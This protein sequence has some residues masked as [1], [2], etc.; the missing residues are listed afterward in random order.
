MREMN[1]IFPLYLPSPRFIIEV[2]EVNQSCIAMAKNRKFTPRTKHITIKYHHVRKHVITQANPD[3][4]I[5]LEYCSTHNQIAD[6]FTKLVWDDIFFKLRKGL[7][8]W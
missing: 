1:E 2:R 6:I 4:F 7:M 8:G 5:S 3:G